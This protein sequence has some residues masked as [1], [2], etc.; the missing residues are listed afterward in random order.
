MKKLRE[1]R[2]QIKKNRKNYEGIFTPINLV[3]NLL[4]FKKVLQKISLAS[5]L[6]LSISC[7]D[8]NN[9]DTD[10]NEVHES[11]VVEQMTRE[12]M[13]KNGGKILK[14]IRFDE[15][16]DSTNNSENKPQK[17]SSF[18][19]NENLT[20]DHLRDLGYYI[21]YRFGKDLLKQDLTYNGHTPTGIRFSRSLCVDCDRSNHRIPNVVITTGEA[22][23][24]IIKKGLS[25][26]D[27]SFPTTAVNKTNEPAEITVGYEYKTGHKT[28]WKRV[29]GGSLKTTVK[30]NVQIPLIAKKEVSVEVGF[31]SSFEDSTEDNKE[32]TY[33]SSYK[34][35]VPARSKVLVTAFTRRVESDVEYTIP[36]KLSGLVLLT[37]ARRP[38]RYIDI[39]NIRNFANSGRETGV[40]HVIDNIG[41]EI[42]ANRPQSLTSRELNN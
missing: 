29:L 14:E 27:F 24:R 25:I 15:S 20:A 31:T 1:L 8:D 19:R 7:A 21:D 16:L 38:F 40:A 32:H 35:I 26:P 37:Y 36:I 22:E 23:V 18:N 5:I 28:T 11:K 3:S 2:V 17:R 12:E 9:N 39:S 6:L 13:L 33:K 30:G 34:V 42:I 4:S 10:I 41:V